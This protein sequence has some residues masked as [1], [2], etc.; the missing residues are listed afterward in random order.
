MQ[1]NDVPRWASEWVQWG[2]N[3]VA[4]M[5]EEPDHPAGHLEIPRLKEDTTM[6][7]TISAALLA[8]SVIAAPA[9]A[10]DSGKTVQAPAAKTTQ[11]PAAKT[12][13]TKT[14]DSKTADI[15]SAQTKPSAMNAKAE[16]S[17]HAKSHRHHRSHKKMSSLKTH[18]VSKVS[19]KQAAPAIKR[20]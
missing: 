14:S 16:M 19:I 2:T 12:S 3:K 9:L 11:V 15:K 5:I 18:K 4:R 17:H 10:A 1:M 20:G 8:A 13:D 6:L 7:K